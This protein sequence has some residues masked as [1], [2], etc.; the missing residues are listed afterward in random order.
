MPLQARTLRGIGEISKN[1]ILVYLLVR[2]GYPMF[3]A[4]GPG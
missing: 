4:W 2:I 3:L 1:P